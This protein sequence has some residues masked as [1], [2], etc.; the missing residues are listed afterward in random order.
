M[1]IAKFLDE[2]ELTKIKVKQTMQLLTK[3]KTINIIF[4]NWNKININI[5]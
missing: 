5:R 1:L 4:I 3:N 2:V